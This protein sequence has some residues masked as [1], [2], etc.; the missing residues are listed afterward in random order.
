[1]LD[2]GCNRGGV[3]AFV[4]VSA[5]CARQDE[6]EENNYAGLLSL[7]CEALLKTWLEVAEYCTFLDYPDACFAFL[8]ASQ[9]LVP[10]L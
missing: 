10:P 8:L 3:I 6:G 4:G 2:S 9:I 1:M 5:R 7:E